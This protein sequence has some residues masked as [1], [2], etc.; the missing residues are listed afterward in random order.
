MFIPFLRSTHFIPQLFVPYNII[1]EFVFMLREH[2]KRLQS[3]LPPMCEPGGHCAKW[4][5]S[6]TAGQVYDLP[7]EPRLVHS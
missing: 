2:H 5:E 7:K 1:K 3:V 6:I 4:N